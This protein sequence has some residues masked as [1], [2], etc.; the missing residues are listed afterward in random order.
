MGQTRVRDKQSLVVR[1]SDA[2]PWARPS[3]EERDLHGL[4][5]MDGLSKALDG[6]EFRAHLSGGS[7]VET[8]AEK[9]P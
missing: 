2:H 3:S 4:G 7:D 5:S 8:P 6:D 9:A 1:L